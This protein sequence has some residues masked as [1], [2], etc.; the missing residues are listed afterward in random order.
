[1]VNYPTIMLRIHLLSISCNMFYSVQNRCYVTQLV[2]K[3]PRR[4]CRSLEHCSVSVWSERSVSRC[5]V[6]DKQPHFEMSRDVNTRWEDMWD[7]GFGGEGGPS[8]RQC[9]PRGM[10]TGNGGSSRRQ[11]VISILRGEPG[12]VLWERDEHVK[13]RAFIFQ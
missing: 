13:R 7:K 3:K 12:A 1:M 9:C 10:M 5:R 8:V 6:I 4:S 11:H 2:P